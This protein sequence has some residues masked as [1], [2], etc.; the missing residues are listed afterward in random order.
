MPIRKYFPGIVYL[1]FD[2][3]DLGYCDQY[4]YE[5]DHFYPKKCK[6]LANYGSTHL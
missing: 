4:V 2:I 6:F 1:N 5:I 3:K